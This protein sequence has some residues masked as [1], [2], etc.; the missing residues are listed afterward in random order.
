MLRWVKRY[1]R[2]LIISGIVLV[3]IGLIIGGIHLEEQRQAEFKQE[4]NQELREHKQFIMDTF[5]SMGSNKNFI[6]SITIEYGQTEHNP[7]G[8]I[9]FYGYVDYDKRLTVYGNLDKNQNDKF[10]IGVSSFSDELNIK[11][12]KGYD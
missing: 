3:M 6:K 2:W 9:D 8:G 10:D 4:M 7:M 12:D 5:N 11:L 1:K